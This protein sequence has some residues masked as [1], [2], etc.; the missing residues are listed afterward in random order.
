M[1]AV[2]L[3][4]V[5]VVCESICTEVALENSVRLSY[6]KQ[7]SVFMRLIIASLMVVAKCQRLKAVVVLQ[8][9]HFIQLRFLKIW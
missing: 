3:K 5:S 7:G 8:G 2:N 6:L 1:I 9:L 4:E